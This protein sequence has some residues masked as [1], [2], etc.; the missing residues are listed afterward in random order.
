[1]PASVWRGRI[2]FGMVSIPVRLHKAA[3][4]ERI[5]FHRVVSR[6]AEESLPRETED[7]EEEAA[8][9]ADEE[10]EPA[11]P[12]PRIQESPRGAGPIAEPKPEQVVRV[13]NT[14]APEA[15]G[16]PILKG[17]EIEKNQY[18]VLQPKEVAALRPRT[19]TELGILEFVLLEEIDPAYFDTSYYVS[20]ERGGEKPYA[21]LFEA[22]R[23]S[24]Y[25]ALG[26]V[27]MHGREHA[28]VI[29][30]AAR[31][32]VLHTLFYANEVRSDEE[33]TSDISLVG[34][35]ELELATMLVQALAAKFEPA[36][37]KDT[38]EERLRELIDT[39]AQS[40]VSSEFP[41][42][43]PRMAPVVDIL[44]ALRKSLEKARKPVKSESG[45][46]KTARPASRRRARAN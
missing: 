37:L 22:L 2:V 41:Q 39:R 4:R 10:P 9:S 20:P 25:V 17:Y 15:A 28:V 40:A 1:M 7:L 43:E 12:A 36:K 21:I 46:K 30:P 8:A 44:E 23:K 42:T 19:S 27:A 26:T 14:P 6:P 16:A 5:R 31:G 33:Y 35:K 38:F 3:R 32:L 13:H 11:V 45:E 18:V 24:D 34:A 29:R